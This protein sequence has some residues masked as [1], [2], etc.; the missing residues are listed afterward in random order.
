MMM[1]MW[2]WIMS[3]CHKPNNTAWTRTYAARILVLYIWITLKH[4]P[5]VKER[6]TQEAVT[7]WRGH[8]RHLTDRN[9]Y[10]WPIMDAGLCFMKAIPFKDFLGWIE[11]VTPLKAQKH[12]CQKHST[13]H[14]HPHYLLVFNIMDKSSHQTKMKKWHRE[15]KRHVKCVPGQWA[16]V[17]HISINILP[18]PITAIQHPLLQWM[19]VMMNRWRD[20][21][22]E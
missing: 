11:P 21:W 16:F 4:K 1:M 15:R 22:I 19:D 5:D 3:I 2:I 20:G 18:K 14:Q 8:S 13:P 17:L 6:C 7:V 10:W 12:V 9:I